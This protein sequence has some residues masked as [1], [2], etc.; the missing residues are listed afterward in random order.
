MSIYK[1]A[2][3]RP[4]TTILIFVA[5]IIIG[6]FS[7]SKLP[8]DQFPEIE[9]P[10]ITVMTTYPGASA[11]EV[12]TNVTKLLENSLNS[13]DGLDE[14]TSTSKDNIS[15]VVLKMEW[16]TNLDEVINDVRSYV[17]MLKD[18]LPDGCSN[19]F[20]FKFSSSAMPIIQ[21]A[22]TAE[23]SYPGLDKILNNDV[24]PLL[25][26]VNGIGNISLSGSPERYVYVDIDQQKLDAYGLTLEN[27]GNVVSANNLNLSSGTVKMDKEQYQMQVRSEYIESSEINDLVVTTTRDGKQVF[28][29]DIATVRDTIK[30]LSLD[31]KTNGYESVR[32]IIT[33]QSGANTVQICEDVQ[34]EMAKIQKTLPS[35]VKIEVIYDSSDHIK[36]SINS[37]KESVLYALL[38]VVLIILFFLGRWRATFIIGITIPIALIVAFI[39]LLFVDSSLNIISL[40]SLTI[41]IGMVVDDAIVVLENIVRHIDRGSNPREASIYGTN[42]VWISVI[43]ST[44]VIVVVFVPLTMLTGMAGIMFK[45]LGWIVTIVVLTS[46]L[47]AISLTPMLSSKLLKG[48]KVK[49]DENGHI[50][51]VPA[52]YNWYQKYVVGFL[53]KVDKW[54][55]KALHVC[56]N[57]K[58]ITIISVILIFV[59][60]LVPVGM[61]LI[62]SDF[63]QQ[64]DNGRL[65]VTVELNRGTRIEET[66][67]TARQLETRF[68]VLAP[69]IRLINTSAGSNDE[70]GISSIFSSTTNNRISMIIVCNKKYERERSIDEI[71]EVLRKELDNYPEIID[72]QCTVG[73]GMRGMV[74]GSS[75]VNVEIY[76]YSFDETNILAENIKRE[77][78]DKVSGARNINIDR[79]EDRAEL[80]ITVDKEKL[81]R[82]GLT[83]AMVSSFVRNRVNGM[84]AGFL[85]E[86]GDEFDIVV[87]LEEEQRNSI[88]DV[89]N[90]SIPTPMGGKVKLNEIAQVGEYWTPPTIAR[91]ARQRIVQVQVTP[92]QTSLGEL[93]VDIQKVVDGVNIPQGITVRL[94]GDYEEQQETFGDIIWLGLLIVMLVY[95]VMASQFESFSKPAII[96]MAV[97]FAFTG[98]ILALWITGTS[99]DI[100]GALGAIMLVGIVVKNG[101]VLVDYTNLM[102][103]RG[104]EL[105]TAIAMSGASRL[106]PVLMTALT[107][108]LG[109]VPMALSSGEGSEMWKPMGIVI[110]GGLL[111]STVITLI[112]VPVLYAVM[113]RHGERNKEMRNRKEFIFMQLSGQDR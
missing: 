66:L 8:I 12:E 62:G 41:A 77:I 74:G 36:N 79:D 94:A 27:V 42:E 104:Y 5:V 44:L 70:A 78:E 92:Y 9:P 96:M 20:I 23:E 80:K 84:P 6:I 99:L 67:K 22:I 106:R 83:S 54:Y 63:M 45:E 11:G 25:N 103:D 91:K 53:D 32:M 40:S 87:R 35:D 50:V 68:E 13:V 107:T 39:Y 34:K 16:G 86:D 14:L 38:L 82:H 88:S 60:S 33:K 21:Y 72:Y 111:V 73:G 101:I 71:A 113:S 102:R 95:I 76:G 100:I 24:M 51:E 7:Y 47:V 65:S 97:P 30:D 46:M 112:V 10:Y 2:I 108:I 64:T 69:E 3:N 105:N 81:A 58:V 59:L 85:K 90:L 31:E 55:A 48:K 28:V 52:K 43:A 57:H 29:R 1:T 110:I 26:R 109:M 98:V 89:E 75:T 4:V 37:L 56:L 19:P 49:I 93:A 18:Y 17:D 61:G 15:L